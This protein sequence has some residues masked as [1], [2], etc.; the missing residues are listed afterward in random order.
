MIKEIVDELVEKICY[1][2]RRDG[3]IE[4]VNTIGLF[5]IDEATQE[6]ENVTLSTNEIIE[7]TQS[8]K[9]EFNNGISRNAIGKN[10]D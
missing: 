8:T 4:S 6:T 3:S 1:G 7:D 10:K 9:E 2:K 5:S